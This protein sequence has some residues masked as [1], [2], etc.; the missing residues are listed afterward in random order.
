MT[1]LGT[2]KFGRVLMHGPLH[3]DAAGLIVPMPWVQRATTSLHRFS[4]IWSPHSGRRQIKGF[5]LF[6]R[7]SSIAAYPQANRA[8][9]AFSSHCCTSLLLD[10]TFY[11]DRTFHGVTP[12]AVICLTPKQWR[13][14]PSS[15][16]TTMQTA[17]LVPQTHLTAWS[18]S[19]TL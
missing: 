2:T 18:T 3:S 6:Q 16:Q 12:A 7:P 11:A 1:R 15:S 10:V 9:A 8:F 13:S 4:A 17:Q 19:T 5:A 14:T